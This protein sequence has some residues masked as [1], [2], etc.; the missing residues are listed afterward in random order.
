MS[1]QRYVKHLVFFNN[2]KLLKVNQGKSRG[3]QSGNA[4]FSDRSE[5]AAA[6]TDL[7]SKHVVRICAAL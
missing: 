5:V 6:V 1:K 3:H 2:K 4:F 7:S